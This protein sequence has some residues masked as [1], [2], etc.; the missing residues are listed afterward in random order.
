VRKAHLVINKDLVEYRGER[1]GGAEEGE[2]ETQD[3]MCGSG[4]VTAIL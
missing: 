4:K 2:L 3:L 1:M